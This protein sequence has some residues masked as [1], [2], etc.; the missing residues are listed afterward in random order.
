M[1]ESSETC[2]ELIMLELD[3]VASV[4]W[5]ATYGERLREMRGKVPMQ[6]L[7]DEVSEKYGYRVT[8]QYIQ[9]LERPFGEKASKTVSFILLRYI[10]AVLGN[11]VQSLFGSP[12]IIEQNK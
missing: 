11:D 10:C 12:K 8:K 2:R 6:R 9:M 7:A 1:A 5:N 3:I 4:N